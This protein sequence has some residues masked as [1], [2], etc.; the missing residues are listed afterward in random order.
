MPI[1]HNSQTS[2]TLAILLFLCRP[3]FSW[4]ANMSTDAKEMPPVPPV[5][6]PCWIEIMASEPQ[7]L[8]VCANHVQLHKNG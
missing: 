4:I 3:H 1:C 5:G 2:S 7:K 8:R 6:A